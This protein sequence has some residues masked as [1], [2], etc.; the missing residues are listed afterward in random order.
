M[1]LGI[2]PPSPR[3]TTAS[4]GAIPNGCSGPKSPS[5]STTTI[6]D[7]GRK[8]LGKKPL[9]NRR[10]SDTYAT[11][12]TKSIKRVTYRSSI[13]RLVWRFRLAGILR[14]LYYWLNR[15]SE[16]VL[17]TE[18]AGLTASFY[19][20]TPWE[21]RALDPAG[22]IGHERHI[23]ELLASSLRL[24]DVFYD[25]GSNFGV[26]AI[27]FGKAVGPTGVVVAI[28]PEAQGYAHLEDNVRLN[29]LDNVRTFRLAL[30]DHTGEEKLYLEFTGASRLTQS[31]V[32]RHGY[33]TVMVMEGDRFVSV[34]NLPNPHVVKIDV[35]GHEGA[36]IRG[37]A[38][39]LA[40]PD[41]RL[42][43][44]EIHPQLLPPETP[45]EQILDLLKS[46]GFNRIEIHQ[47]GTTE[48]HALA[49]KS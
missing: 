27:L 19:V 31:A 22:D 8:T 49:Y 25:I 40:Q 32:T 21:L 9:V 20:R 10:S 33:E 39:T 16:N 26:Y 35:E 37:L 45:P 29:S 30:G 15:P 48:F 24:G 3:P 14:T 11:R 2:W 4:I 5:F 36:V 12:L 6:G 13:S 18:V 41:C 1:T 28:E 38:K 46:L 7:W 34:E 23:L 44:C 43:C 47:R 17:H 42:L